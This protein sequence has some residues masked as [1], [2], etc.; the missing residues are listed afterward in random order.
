MISKVVVIVAVLTALATPASPQTPHSKADANTVQ[1][2]QLMD[3]NNNGKVSRAEFMAYMS[4]EFDRLDVNHDGE[5]D[6]DEL[7]GLRVL[8]RHPGGGSK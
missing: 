7:S 5:L 4:G 2:L 6:P 1:L 8:S 3:K